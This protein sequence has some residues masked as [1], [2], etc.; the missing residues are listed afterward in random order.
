MTTQSDL[1]PQGV[2]SAAEEQS[3]EAARAI[4]TRRA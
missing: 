3:K 2:A 4:S 1:V